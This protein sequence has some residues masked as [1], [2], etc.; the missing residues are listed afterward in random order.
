MEKI[1]TSLNKEHVN[2]D[3]PSVVSVLQ[4]IAHSD[5]IKI[6]EVG[7]VSTALAL[8]AYETICWY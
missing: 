7:S 5:R 6:L 3:N 4:R 8:S 1:V 2:T